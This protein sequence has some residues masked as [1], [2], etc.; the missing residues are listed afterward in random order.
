LINFIKTKHPTKGEKEDKERGPKFNPKVHKYKRGVSQGSK[1]TNYVPKPSQVTRSISKKE[2][3]GKLVSVISLEKFSLVMM[4][5]IKIEMD[6]TFYKVVD[7][8][9]L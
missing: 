9:G 1:V 4:V 7:P 3:E 6:C 2:R 8:F 5:C